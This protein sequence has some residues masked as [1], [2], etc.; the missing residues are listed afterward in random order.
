MPDKN[1]NNKTGNN[2]NK[3]ININRKILNFFH[4]NNIEGGYN[5]NNNNK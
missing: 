4:P 3:N 1:D 5:K 2:N